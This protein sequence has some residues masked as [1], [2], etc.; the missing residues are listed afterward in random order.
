MAV[1]PNQS[2]D[3]L[4]DSSQYTSLILQIILQLLKLV[5]HV[6]KFPVFALS[7][8]TLLWREV[9]FVV[10]LVVVAVEKLELVLEFFLDHHLNFFRIFIAVLCYLLPQLLVVDLEEIGELGPFLDFSDV[11]DDSHNDILESIVPADGVLV[12]TVVLGQT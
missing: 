10:I 1:V 8:L 5:H 2:I 7:D 9:L 12:H 4:Y 6:G 11:Q 3:F